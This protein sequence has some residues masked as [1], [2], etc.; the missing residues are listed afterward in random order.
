MI[1]NGLIRSGDDDAGAWAREHCF[2]LVDELVAPGIESE[3]GAVMGVVRR[4]SGSRKI[5]VLRF[6]KRS[7]RC[8]ISY[9]RLRRLA[10]VLR[11][12]IPDTIHKV[13]AEAASKYLKR[14]P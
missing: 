5:I 8:R 9:A 4:R 12:S 1:G 10:R 3:L 13:L 6:P 7:T 14:W 2:E 11:L